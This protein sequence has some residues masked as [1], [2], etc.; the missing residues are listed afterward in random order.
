MMTNQWQ[1]ANII[2]GV[3]GKRPGVGIYNIDTGL[4]ENT[5]SLTAG[6]SVYAVDVLPNS[7]SLIVGTRAGFL[8]LLGQEELSQQNSDFEPQRFIQ[9]ASVL[10]VCSLDEQR[11]AVSDVAGRCLIWELTK[12]SQPMP[13]PTGDGAVCALF[14]AD[15]GLLAGISMAG[16]L[17]VWDLMQSDIIRVLDI[18]TPP[19]LSA[20]IKPIYWRARNSWAWPGKDGVVVL[21]QC[22]QNKI[23]TMN[24]HTGDVY[25]MA[26]CN[27]ELLTIGRTDGCMKRWQANSDKPVASFKA[28]K[29]VISASI[30]GGQDF[31]M[32][33]INDLGKAGIYSFIN[34]KIK[35]IGLLH[36][37][38]YR[39]TI[40]PDL[41]KYQAQLSQKKIVLAENISLQIKDKIAKH[42]KKELDIYIKF[43]NKKIETF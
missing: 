33:L 16:E 12:N 22:S 17:V 34:D 3:G 42:V 19:A 32:L 37:R 15:D 14:R 23:T 26:V 5:I 9:G 10:S 20:L 21:Y 43:I 40:D 25:A 41:D 28:P 2:L 39:I 7:N 38:D 13:L 24:A 8:Y 1:S 27:D 35:F 29:G 30:W 4:I 6:E 18:P 31:R 11:V 36:G